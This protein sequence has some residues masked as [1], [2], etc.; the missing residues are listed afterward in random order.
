MGRILRSSFVA[1]SLVLTAPISV[2]VA[3]YIPPQPPGY[4]PYPASP[5]PPYQGMHPYPDAEVPPYDAQSPY[6]KQPM[7]SD[8]QRQQQLG[9]HQ[10]GTATPSC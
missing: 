1:I 7:S 2:A 9:R 4:Y 8:E 6:Q 10:V 5:P 3:Q